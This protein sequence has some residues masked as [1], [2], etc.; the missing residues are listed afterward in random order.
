MID[1]IHSGRLHSWEGTHASQ[2]D[3]QAA[4]WTAAGLLEQTLER[5]KQTITPICGVSLSE[6]E[7]S[8]AL[9][10]VR[11]QKSVHCC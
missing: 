5:R 10:S 4:R 11:F 9:C 3:R 8:G 7:P 6:S 2:P 1:T